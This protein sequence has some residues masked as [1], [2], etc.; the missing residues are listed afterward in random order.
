MTKSN[1]NIYKIFFLICILVFIYLLNNYNYQEYFES[2]IESESDF[3]DKPVEFIGD[4]QIYSENN[5]SAEEVVLKQNVNLSNPYDNYNYNLIYIGFDGSINIINQNAWTNLSSLKSFNAIDNNIV[6]S[7]KNFSVSKI[8]QLNTGE[9][10]FLGPDCFVYKV[11]GDFT[12]P[13]LVSNLKFTSLTQLS[14]YKILLTGKDGKIYLVSDINNFNNSIEKFYSDNTTYSSVKQTFDGLIVAI[15]GNKC[16]T[17]YSFELKNNQLTN[18]TK[19]N[20]DDAYTNRVTIFTPDQKSLLNL[21]CYSRYI[22]RIYKFTYSDKTFKTSYDTRCD[23]DE[24]YVEILGDGYCYKKCPEGYQ[25]HSSDPTTCWK[26]CNPGDLD[27]GDLCMEDC[28]DGYKNIS[29]IC[30]L[31]KKL[32]YDRGIGIAPDYSC[33]DGYDL[34]GIRCI[35]KPPE[36]YKRLPG[37]YTTYWLKDSTSYPRNSKEAKQDNSACT[38]LE[39][40]IYGIGS[41]TGTVPKKCRT[42]KDV[43]GDLE[44]VACGTDTCTGTKPKVCRTCKDVCGDL[45]NVL[46][47]TDTCT[48]T[49][50]KVCRTCNDVCG[51]LQNVTCVPGSTC[52]GTKPKVCRT[53]KDVCGDLDGIACASD[54]CTGTTKKTCRTCKDVCGDLEN[55]ACG[56]DSCTGTKPKV[57]RTCNDV[58]GDLNGIVCGP[59]SCTGSKPKVCRTCNDVCGDLNGVACTSD[60]CTGTKP[61][62]CRT[63]NDVCGDLEPMT[64]I[65]DS[66]CSGNTKKTCRTCKDVCGDLENVACATDSCTGT[67]PKVCR[68][69]KDVCGDLNGAVCGTDSCT[70]TTQKTCR[71]CKDVCGDLENVACTLDS[72]T[73]TK[74]KVCRTC[75]DVCGDLN[76]VACGSDSCTGTTSKTCRTCNDVCGDLNGVI[77]GTDSCTGSTQ[78]TCRTCKDVC[79]DLNGVT[80]GPDSCTGTKPKVCR[81]CNDVCGDLKGVTCGT[82]TCTGTKPKTCRTCKDACHG[83]KSITCGSDTCSGWDGAVLKTRSLNCTGGNVVTRNLDCSGGEVV[84]RGLDCTG[85]NLV[86]RGLDCKGGNVVTRGLDCKGGESVSRGL[87]CKG[88]DVVTRGLDCKGGEPVTRGLDCKGGDFVTRQLDCKGGEVVT[89][90]LDCSGGDVVT[91]GLDCKG[92]EPVTRGLDCKGGDVVTRGLDCKGGELVTRDL[93]CSGGEPVTRG[94]DCKGGEPVTR[95]LDCTGGYVTTR[96]SPRTC[97]EGYEFDE[98]GLLCYESCRDGYESRPGD[99]VS[100]W[101]KKPTSIVIPPENTINATPS[102]KSNRILQDAMCYETCLDGYVGNATMCNIPSDK[103]SYIPT[104]YAK[105]TVKREYA[106]K[107]NNLNPIN[108]TTECCMYDLAFYNPLYN[109]P[110]NMVLPDIPVVEGLVGFYNADSFVSNIWYDISPQSNNAVYVKGN[111]TNNN[112]YIE[113]TSNSTILFPIQILPSQYTVFNVAKYSGINKGKI[114]SG[115]NNNWFSG[116][117]SGLSGVSGRNKPITQTNLNVFDDNWVFSTDLNTTY[118]ANGN[119]LTTQNVDSNY[120]TQLCINL[121]SDSKSNSDFA[122]GCVIVFNRNLSNEEILKIESWLTSKYSDLWAGTYKQTFAQQGYSCF[123]GSIGK[124]VRNYNDFEYAT[125]NNQVVG[126][127]WLNLPEKNNLTQMSCLTNINNTTENFETFN[128]FESLSDE[129]TNILNLTFIVSI[130]III[131]ILIYKKI[132]KD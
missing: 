114:L 43:C 105:N 70:G 91:R 42:C 85:G 54:T 101:N 96:K 86:T 51:D 109:K 39:N 87:D 90:N 113:G 127:E 56:T 92:G 79:G 132:N 9:F 123:N 44:N 120:P 83:L 108:C 116:F 19:I 50:P 88:G 3:E 67:K 33:P 89:R 98:L 112:K 130:G 31:D 57:C 22:D 24:D 13:I 117:N 126:C 26:K 16:G 58:C 38:D 37:D 6:K 111:F 102:C 76:G 73:G 69:C 72:C 59:D 40:V 41:C 78:K 82:D 80:C 49:K 74:P 28:R 8:T 104:T 75:K 46:C 81:T 10:L 110:E 62:V 107:P 17:S 64:C 129:T 4:T 122:I 68:T 100:C 103:A 121:N 93:D 118:R 14:N 12:N 84:T 45:Q 125:Y 71:T 106:G 27:T 128:N 55:V 61:K 2:I 97:P 1:N 115:Y 20:L 119:N 95:S 5:I 29:G 63:C 34:E 131:F 35:K 124:I 30:W 60:T 32:T 52:T 21:N 94:L 15:D 77:C 18:K 7:Y 66:T 48:G 53:C 36:G 99:V 47:G 11:K 65:P 23:I 25:T